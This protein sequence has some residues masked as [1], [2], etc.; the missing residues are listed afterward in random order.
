MQ[1]LLEVKDFHYYYGNIHVVKGIDLYVNEGEMVTLIGANGAGKTT[2]LRTIS[3]LT[4]AAGMRGEITFGGKRI[5][6]MPG[7]KITG[8][9]LAQVLEGRHVFSKLSVSENLSIGAYLRNDTAGIKE[10]IEKMYKLFPRLKERKDQMAGTLSGGEQQMLAIARALVGRPKM[11]LLDEPSLG[12]APIIIHEIFAAVK[13][14]NRQGTT[15][16]FVEQN[17][18]IALAT[19]HRGYVFQTGQI[20]MHD[21]CSNLAENEEVKKAYM[22]EE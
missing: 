5:D 8:L 22:G 19:A 13:E 7:N 10:D 18:K 2:T 16:M 15:I 4:E 17:S 6:K 12:L 21:T 9:G 14:I 3:G 20:V 11:V 1:P